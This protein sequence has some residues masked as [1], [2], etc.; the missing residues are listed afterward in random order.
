MSSILSF[1]FVLQNWQ[2]Y[3]YICIVGVLLLNVWN[4]IVDFFGTGI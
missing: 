1:A 2:L 4:E 3:I